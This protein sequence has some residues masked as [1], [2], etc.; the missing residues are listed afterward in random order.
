MLSE[1]EISD[2]IA[3]A[4]RARE[5][6]YAPYSGFRVGAALLTASG[7]V[8][9]GCNVE[10]AS[11]GATICA[12]RSAVCAAVAAGEHEF[13]ALAV[14]AGGD[15]VTPCGICRQVLAEFSK[16]GGLAVICESG[17]GYKAYKLSSLLPEAFTEFAREEKHRETGLNK[18]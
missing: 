2:L 11:Y 8:Y 14:T 9:S 5:R 15:L 12:E 18:I 17:G 4:Q 7:G 3:C 13:K 1:T 6:A 16:D 10:N